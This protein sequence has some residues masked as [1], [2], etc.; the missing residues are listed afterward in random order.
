MTK[1]TAK[2]KESTSTDKEGKVTKL[3][4]FSVGANVD[5]GG[6]LQDM[7]KKFGESVVFKQALGAMTVSFQGWLRSQGAQGKNQAEIDAGARAWKPGER[8]A[9]K[10]PQEKMRELL[11]GMSADEKAQFLKEFRA[12]AKAA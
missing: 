3:A 6:N 12:P 5:F 8:K 11:N 2:R 10:T 4:A 1:V 9:S 7:V